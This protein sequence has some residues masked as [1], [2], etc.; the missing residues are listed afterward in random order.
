VPEKLIV[1]M[2]ERKASAVMR[3]PAFLKIWASPGFEPQDLLDGEP[4]VHTGY[5][6]QPFVVRDILLATEYPGL[7]PSYFFIQL[8]VE[9]LSL[10]IY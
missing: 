2:A 9:H 1:R 3:P 10:L 5:D 4:L 7:S 8:L 6:K